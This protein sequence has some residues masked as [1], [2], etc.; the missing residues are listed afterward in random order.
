MILI[1]DNFDL[2][3]ASNNFRNSFR[4][5]KIYDNFLFCNFMSI[6]NM[7]KIFKITRKNQII[8]YFSERC[9][10]LAINV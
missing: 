8:E 9:S 10:Y 7:K 4:Q 6:P 1:I 3:K 5:C 2:L